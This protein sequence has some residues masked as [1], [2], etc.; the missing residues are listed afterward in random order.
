MSR[1]L[2]FAALVIAAC[3]GSSALPPATPS[4]TGSPSPSGEPS[5]FELAGIQRV[6][7]TAGYAIGSAGSGFALARTLDDGATWKRITVPVRRVSEV[8][9]ITADA[10]WAIGFAGRGAQIGCQQASPAPPCRSVVLRTD[11]GGATWTE[12]LSVPFGESGGEMLRSLQAVDAAN[13]WV[14]V[15]DQTCPALCG[16]ELRGTS[17]GGKSWRTLYQ[18]NIGAIRFVSPRRGWIAAYGPGGISYGADGGNL[19]ATA[20]GGVSWSLALKGQPIIAIEAFDQRVWALAVDSAYCSSS[21]CEK[22]ELF[23]SA[24]SGSTWETFGNPKNAIAAPC[25]GGHLAGPVFASA[26]RGWFG[27]NEGAGGAVGIGSIVASDDD[28]VTWRCARPEAEV[29]LLSAADAEH[30]WAVDTGRGRHPIQ[31]LGSDDGGKTW[32]TLDLSSLR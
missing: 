14:V 17:D 5:V 23:S 4:V 6:S 20:D 10:G 9:F 19:L 1:S 30:L 26:S 29:A 7:R 22:Y 18:G 21:S 28:G 15:G 24:D 13:A 32:R 16:N 12:T 27:L 3:A 2:L 31:L 11:D 25:G 8:R